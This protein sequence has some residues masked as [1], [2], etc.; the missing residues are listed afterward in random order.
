MNRDEVLEAIHEYAQWT[1]WI[2]SDGYRSSGPSSYKQYLAKFS[3]GM[4]DLMRDDHL[5]PADEIS[6][7]VYFRYIHQKLWAESDLLRN[8]DQRI[9]R[10]VEGRIADRGPNQRALRDAWYEKWGDV[11]LPGDVVIR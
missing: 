9:V 3:E 11:E 1:S 10:D 5:V 8:H 7:D 2:A 6:A 4:R